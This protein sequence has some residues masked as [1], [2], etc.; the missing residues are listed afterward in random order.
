[1]TR[2]KQNVVQ[3]TNVED[4]ILGS[5]EGD[6]F[7]QWIADN[8]DHNTAT[9]D[10]KQTFHRMGIV[11][12]TTGQFGV[13]RVGLRHLIPRQKLIKAE[14]VIRNKGARIV[15][16]ISSPRP[17]ISGTILRPL[18]RLNV[19]YTPPVSLKYQLVW[20]AGYYCRN[21]ALLRPSWSG[22]MQ[23]A[24][25]GDYPSKSVIYLFPVIGLNPSDPTCICS[26]LLY[27]ESQAKKLNI[28]TPCITYDQPL[29]VKAMDI[30]KNKSMNIVC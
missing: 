29:W 22:F 12:A 21:K 11:S 14:H 2:F 19:L 6:S 20:I 5:H 10:G 16:Y 28:V 17:G 4:F 27:N 25:S 3:S 7:T 13:E 1:M 15:Q 26:A 8:V 23:D 18:E 30:I 9:I 24:N